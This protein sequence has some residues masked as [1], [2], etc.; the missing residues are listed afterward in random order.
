MQTTLSLKQSTTSQVAITT[1]ASSSN[2]LGRRK[3]KK[4]ATTLDPTTESFRKSAA[5]HLSTT[6]SPPQT[7]D[8]KKLKSSKSNKRLAKSK[9]PSG[10][11]RSS[12]TPIQDKLNGGRK[13]K[14]KG[15]KGGARRRAGSDANTMGLKYQS[16]SSPI[17]LKVNL[18]ATKPKGKKKKFQS[19]TPQKDYIGD[20]NMDDDDPFGVKKKKKKKKSSVTPKVSLSTTIDGPLFSSDDELSGHDNTNQNGIKSSK[21]SKKA[22]ARAMSARYAT[23]HD[24]ISKS[25]TFDMEPNEAPTF[26]NSYSSSM[27]IKPMKLTN[28]MTI[29][30]GSKA[31]DSK[32]NGIRKEINS[33]FSEFQRSLNNKQEELLNDLESVY[34]DKRDELTEIESKLFNNAKKSKSSKTKE[35]EFDPNINLILNKPKILQQIKKYGYIQGIDTNANDDAINSQAN[36]IFNARMS[37]KDSTVIID[38]D[39]KDGDKMGDD[40]DSDDDEMDNG[41]LSM[42]AKQKLILGEIQQ[43]TMDKLDIVIQME[44]E[45]AIVVFATCEVVDCFKLSVVCICCVF[46]MTAL[47][48]VTNL[49]YNF[50]FDY[51]IFYTICSSNCM[52]DDPKS[53]KECLALQRLIF[54]L[55]YYSDLITTNNL[56]DQSIFIRFMENIYGNQFLNDYIHLVNDHIYNL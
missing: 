27:K 41:E 14:G 19:Q 10:G 2:R 28:S 39:Y 55:N 1:M 9:S 7:S 35:F 24:N 43:K 42:A 38:D 34:D 23:N 33:S 40:L 44:R 47:Q 11:T 30:K 18:S 16:P 54:T 20:L 53:I 29:Q 25:M 12:A 31:L 13:K 52:R 8:D 6:P 4:R 21:K 17:S 56:N 45:E 51:N 22:S 50:D 36:A 48:L 49:I 32:M 46:L 5:F 15:K 26:T 3:K 37:N